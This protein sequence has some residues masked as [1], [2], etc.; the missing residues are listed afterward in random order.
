MSFWSL[1][2]L[3][4]ILDTETDANS[5]G[6]EELMSQIR[7]NIE[8][9][10]L[11]LLGTGISGTATSDPSNDANG[12]FY[13]TG[14]AWTDDLHNG[15]TLLITSGAAKGN[16]YV[17]DDTV[18]GSD[19]LDCTGDNLY[20]DGV[21]S[22]DSYKILYDL[23]VN[24]DG[25]DHDGINSPPPVFANNYITNVKL[26]TAATSVSGSGSGAA[27]DIAMQD[28]SFMPNCYVQ[29]AGSSET[30]GARA[31]NTA[32]YAGRFYLWTNTAA[33]AVY[34][35]YIT[36]SDEPFIYLVREKTTGKILHCWMAEDPPP[37]YWGLSETPEN[38]ERPVIGYLKDGKPEFD[39]D[40]HEEIIS[41]KVKKDL[42]DAIK[43]RQK[44]DKK[45]APHKI[46][47]DQFEFDKKSSLWKAKNLI[48]I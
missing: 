29:G 5:P 21:R 31:T 20:A 22:G 24:T 19:R 43:D 16:M 44:A 47:E 25:H 7:E 9:L 18:N 3:R 27:V 26:K 13:D 36:S 17:I 35:R 34:F 23:K 1:A 28:Y 14:S 38:F 40:K 8:A 2:A 33:F 10:I 39:P 37:G 32:D 4:T 12:Y 41:W 45:T 48:T 30:L 42:F 15:R 6:S 11:L 46:I